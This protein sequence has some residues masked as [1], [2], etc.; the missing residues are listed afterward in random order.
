M[1]VSFT[2]AGGMAELAGKFHISKPQYGLCKVGSME[3]G[4]PRIAM[5]SWVSGKQVHGDTH[6]STNNVH[7]AHTYDSSSYRHTHAYLDTEKVI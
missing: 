5:I 7:F 4:G 6:T 2:T 1:S 3:T